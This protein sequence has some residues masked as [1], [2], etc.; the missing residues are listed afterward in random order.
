[1]RFDRL[2]DSLSRSRERVGVRVPPA[3]LTPALSRR[4]RGG[5]GSVSVVVAAAATL[6]TAQAATLKPMT[7]LH[8]SVVRLS[9]LFDD[10]G[11]N[12]D[13][14]LG[15]GPAPGSRIVVESRQLAAIA[16]SFGVDW[17]PDFAAERAVLERPGRPLRR[18]EA[19]AALTE[20]L[21][22]AGA[23]KDAEFEIAAFDP[24]MVPADG[25]VT[26]IVTQLDYDGGSGRFTAQLGLS[27]AGMDATAW[28]VTGRAEPM[29]E[30]AVAASRLL[31]GSILSAA[32]LR[33]ARLPAT[34]VP[35]GAVS[36]IE[37]AVGKQLRIQAAPGAPLPISELT[38]PTLVRRDARVLMLAETPGLSLSAEGR[39]LENGAAGEH[40]RVLNPSSRA[41][42]DA[43]VIGVGRVRIDPQAP[44][45]TPAGGER[46]SGA[47]Y[48]Q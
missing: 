28:R 30:V 41:V 37:D 27:G 20:A 15:P 33:M 11:R 5:R 26:P 19:M 23:P 24:P 14:V 32:D 18:A 44:P 36:R 48:A 8:A 34:R 10:A 29:L 7:T 6:A 46:R 47:E 42:L 43:V 22:S 9:D 2:V 40:V 16:R 31:P 17:R 3:P 4:T 1:M 21:V 45:L 38:V 25:T 39:A 13:R 12:A 35:A